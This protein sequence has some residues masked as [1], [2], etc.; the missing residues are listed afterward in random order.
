MSI[1][2]RFTLGDAFKQYFEI[3][4]AFSTAL[5]DEVYRV[6]HQVYCEDLGF[7]PVRPDRRETDEHDSNS[8][9]LLMRNVKTGEF[10][11]CTRIVRPRQG[12]PHY[13]LPFEKSCAAALDRSIVDPAKLPRHH[14]AEVSRLAVVAGYR[15]RKGEENSAVGISSEDFG[16]P[17]QPRFPFIPIGLYLGT[18]ELARLNGID[19]LFVLTEERLANH[20]DKLG[21]QLQY[22]G[23]QIEHHGKRVP[24]MMGIS[25]II[26]NMRSN[27][28][29]LY[30]A[31]AT[32]IEKNYHSRI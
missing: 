16:T 6:R 15:R 24:S 2:E 30:R 28:R 11:G 22:I 14:I 18:T 9:H 3:V 12:D 21:F 10:V 17:K 29:P 13:Q 27:L 23:Q 19:T 26:N 1:P 31:I 8:L 4:P 5:K 32:D 7:E 20:F 25:A